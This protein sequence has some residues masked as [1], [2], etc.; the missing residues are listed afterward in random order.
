M[1]MMP[2]PVCQWHYCFNRVKLTNFESK[3][4][5]KKKIQAVMVILGLEYCPFWQF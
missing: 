1:L 5:S 2:G 4:I 3:N